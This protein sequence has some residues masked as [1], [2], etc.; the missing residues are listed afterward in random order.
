[1][2]DVDLA[3]ESAALYL[4]ACLRAAVKPQHYPE[5]LCLNCDEDLEGAKRR[6]CDSYCAE[7]FQKR[8]I[9]ERRQRG[10]AANVRR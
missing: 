6:F 10:E 9:I 5:G 3:N 2:D 1:M 4:A 8:Q 7:D